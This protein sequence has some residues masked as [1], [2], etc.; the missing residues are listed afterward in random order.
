[1]GLK[2]IKIERDMAKSEEGSNN[3][4]RTRRYYKRIRNKKL[5]V[6]KILKNIRNMMIGNFN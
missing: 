4:M 6:L 3:M 2:A 1:M 5:G